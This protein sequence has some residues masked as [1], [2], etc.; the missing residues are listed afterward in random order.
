MR[1]SV[2]GTG[3]SRILHLHVAINAHAQVQSADHNEEE[4]RRDDGE[5]NGGDA[6]NGLVFVADESA[7][8]LPHR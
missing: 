8:R 6:A 4:N 2:L 1:D 3:L 5:L 7:K